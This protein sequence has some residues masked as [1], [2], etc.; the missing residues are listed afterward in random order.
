[1]KPVSVRRAFVLGVFFLSASMAAA[2]DGPKK[3]TTWMFQGEN[4]VLVL[5][6]N[7]DEHYTNGVRFLGLRH[8]EFAPRWADTFAGWFCGWACPDLPALPPSVGFAFG[9]NLYTPDDLSVVELIEDDRPYAAWLY[10]A[11]LLQITDDQLRKQHSFELQLGIVGPAAGGE[12]V[13]TEIHKLIDSE[14]PLGWDNQLPDEPGINLIYRYRRRLGGDSGHFDFVPHWGG[15]LGTIMVMAN[16]GGTVRA[17]WNITGFPQT[18]IPTT[19]EPLAA[20]EREKWEFYLFAGADG[21]AVA[22]NIFL[23]GTVFSDSHSVDKEDFVYDLTAGFSLRY[24][25]FRFQYTYVRR[26]REFSPRRGTFDG[27][28]NYGSLSIG[29]ERAF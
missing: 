26:S 7:T 3:W 1:M 21:R 6:E 25:D 15:A 27:V 24:K 16:A 17:G 20:G 8:P 12:W 18:L 11:A 4:D 5:N 10:G 19:A 9:Q 28:H 29:V 13:Q 14:P 23:D 2:Q 22:H